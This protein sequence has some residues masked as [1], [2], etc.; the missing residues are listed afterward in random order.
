LSDGKYFWFLEKLGTQIAITDL[1]ATPEAYYATGHGD[2][3]VV[4]SQ[5][6]SQTGGGEFLSVRLVD[7]A[8]G[9][10]RSDVVTS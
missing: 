2:A 4:F 7:L 5:Q 3:T 1:R 8:Q 6:P 9:I 10:C